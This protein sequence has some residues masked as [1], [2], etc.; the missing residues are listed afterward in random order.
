MKGPYIYENTMSQNN[1]RRLMDM[2]LSDRTRRNPQILAVLQEHDP[3]RVFFPNMYNKLAAR[4]N[5]M[6]KPPR[7]YMKRASAYVYSKIVTK[8]SPSPSSNY[9]NRIKR[10]IANKTKK[11]SQIR[12]MIQA[13]ENVY[14]N[15]A[16]N[17]MRLLN[18]RGKN[19]ATNKYIKRIGPLAGKSKTRINYIKKYSTVPQT[20]IRSIPMRPRPPLTSRTM[21]PRPPLKKITNHPRLLRAHRLRGGA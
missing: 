1:F 8:K 20:P 6:V 10:A 13:F 5:K 21:R 3:K 9:E 2:E 12:L 18:A 4:Q 16:R 15:S 7:E 14:P 11:S 17:L 19:V